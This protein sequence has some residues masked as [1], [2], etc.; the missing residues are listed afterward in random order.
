MIA[1]RSG[2]AGASS[3]G[4]PSGTAD[5]SAYRHLLRN[6]NYRFWFSSALLSGLGDWIGLVALQTLVAGLFAD[7]GQERLQLFALSGIMMA[8]LL[9]SLLVGP[10]AGVFADR[11]DRKR[12]MVFTHL[13]RGV[14]FVGIAFT[15][16][17][18]ALFALTLLVEFLSLLFLSAKDASLPTIVDR[19]HLKE[20]NQLNLLVTYGTLPAGATVATA[21]IVF[22]EFL[23]FVGLGDVNPVIAALLVNA[24]TFV[25]AGTLLARLHL[26]RSRRSV[27]ADE[28]R[29]GVISELREGL[30]FIRDL[31]VVRALITGVVGVAF[32]AGAFVSLGP[33]FVTQTLGRLEQDWFI[34]MTALG[35]GLVL[36]IA[37][38]PRVTRRVRSERA[39]A[40]GLVAVA[41][42]AIATA[43]RS[44]FAVVLAGGGVLGGVVGFSFVLGY[45]LLHQHTP[46]DVRARTFAAFY[47]GTRLAMFA[48]LALA[49]IVAAAMGRGTLIVGQAVITHSGIRITMT[50]AGILALASAVTAGR[51]LWKTT[52]AATRPVEL[53]ARSPVTTA[54]LFVAFEGVEG[55]GKSTQVQHLAEA[56]RAEGREVVVTREPGGTPVAEQ[57]RD[58]LLDP[59]GAGMDDRTE[60][61]LYAAARAEHVATVIRPALEEGKV[62]LCDRFIDSSLVY[63]GMARQLGEDDIAEINRWATQGLLPDAVVLLRLDPEE[64]LARAAA[65]RGVGDGGAAPA[66]R[67]EREELA[68][69]RAVSAGYLK[70]AKLHHRRF[71]VVDASAPPDAVARQVRAGLHAWAP[72]ADDVHD[73]PRPG[74]PHEEASAHETDPQ[75]ARS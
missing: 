47:T 31:P 44:T 48:S 67:L 2:A 55:S 34:L 52:T 27:A 73:P 29:S 24:L 43:T 40:V 62:V 22:A 50:I 71:V 45:T 70:L 30:R 10:V 14:L 17:L 56:L 20:A 4:G 74:P 63:Q 75:G 28:A 58:V 11:Y 32:G 65:R 16:D 26:P 51:A 21:M 8:R 49:P 60:A 72:L 12:L 68:F 33:A 53:L 7:A 36:G 35:V 37:V 41:V 57:I 59:A 66:D 38:T 46:N 42:A 19:R 5:V 3:G 64:G 39:F 6:R 25:L 23:E 69:H 61:L 9:P 13:T 54:G 1:R 15:G 18:I